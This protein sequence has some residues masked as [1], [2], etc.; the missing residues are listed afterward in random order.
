[1]LTSLSFPSLSS[2]GDSN[3]NGNIDIQSNPVLVSRDAQGLQ[4]LQGREVA[5]AQHAIRLHSEQGVGAS[6][7]VWERK[8]CR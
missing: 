8:R 7:V 5:H 1:M 2:I 4:R 6:M 3:G